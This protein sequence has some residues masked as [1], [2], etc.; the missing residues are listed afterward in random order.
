MERP[1]SVDFVDIVYQGEQPP[2]YIH[3]PF[4]ANREAV[5]FKVRSTCIISC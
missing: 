5:L 1:K 3:F 4:G 2:L